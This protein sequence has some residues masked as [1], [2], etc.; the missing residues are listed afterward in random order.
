LNAIISL[1][2]ILGFL[3]GLLNILFVV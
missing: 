3:I 1:G 2:G